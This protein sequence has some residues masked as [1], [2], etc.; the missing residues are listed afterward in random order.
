MAQWEKSLLREHEDMSS[1]SQR[2]HRA[3]CYK[4][5]CVI[6]VM[7][8]ETETKEAWGPA[9]LAHAA[10]NGRERGCSQAS[11]SMLCG[12]HMVGCTSADKQVHTHTPA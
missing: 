1:N 10:A 8:W 3:R 4:D 9:S 6:P 12:M 7:G 2:P 5:T 11:V